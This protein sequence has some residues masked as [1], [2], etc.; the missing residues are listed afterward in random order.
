[1]KRFFINRGW[2]RIE[3]PDPRPLANRGPIADKEAE[4]INQ[5]G[6]LVSLVPKDKVPLRRYLDQKEWFMKLP[7]FREKENNRHYSDAH[8][9]DTTHYQNDFR[10]NGFIGALSLI[11]GLA[12]VIGPIWGLWWLDALRTETRNMI[13]ITAF[14]VAFTFLLWS[15]MVSRPFETLGAAAA[16]AAVLMVFMQL[17]TGGTS[18]VAT[19]ANSI[20]LNS[21]A[22]YEVYF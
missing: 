18:A 2:Q 12:F 19:H 13:L 4:F 7:F 17:S 14:I 21:T 20:P 10:V 9:P 6:D 1:M 22:A 11:V 5:E 3:Q 8:S 16:Y 15:I